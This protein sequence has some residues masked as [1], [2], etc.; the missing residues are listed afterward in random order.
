MTIMMKKN[1]LA[2][3]ATLVALSLLPLVRAETLRFTAVLSGANEVPA[4]SSSG[5]GRA[6]M[7]INTVSNTYTI[8]VQVSGLSS[9]L[10]ASHIHEGAAG[11]NGPVVQNLGGVASYVA[12]ANRFYAGKFT[13][14]YAGNVATLI[15]GGAYVNVHSANVPSGELRGQLVL[16][17]ASQEH[18][19]N[20]SSRGL[21]N[22]GN[23]RSGTVYGGF[24]LASER[25]VTIRVLGASLSNLGVSNAL[26][27]AAVDL[28]NSAGVQIATNDNWASTQPLA[29]RATGLA[30]LVA[31]DAAITR[32]LAAGTYTAQVDSAKGAGVAVLEIYSTPTPTLIGALAA[33]GQFNT[34]IAAVQAAGLVDVLSGPGPFT[35]FAPTDAAFAKLPAGTLNS[36]LLPANKATLTGILIYHLLPAKV[37]STQLSEGQ[38]AATLQGGN[39]TITLAGGA[40]VNSANI[41]E[42]DLVVQSGVIHPIDAVLMP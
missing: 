22:P 36:L 20:F 19:L 24:V 27:D 11:A 15:R 7:T 41:T 17:P 21:I 8:F 32:T 13:G 26:P 34:L 35:L 9:A 40:K 30:P 12:A 6:D 14:T 2:L 18:L 29:V 3:G 37:L 38:S 5:S 25:T 42:V 28:F 1:I 23:G 33:A 16:V 39:V 4:V 10:A 31:S